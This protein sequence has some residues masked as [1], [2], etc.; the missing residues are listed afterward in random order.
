MLI[1]YLRLQDEDIILWGFS[2]GTYPTAKVARNRKLKG[3]ILQSPLASI[4]SLFADQLT[5]STSFKNDCFSLID[6]IA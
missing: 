1:S 2:L 3:V 4:Y 6:C 5:P